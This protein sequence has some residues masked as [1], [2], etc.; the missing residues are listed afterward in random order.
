MNELKVVKSLPLES[1]KG[2]FA[3]GKDRVMIVYPDTKRIERWSLH[4]YEKELG[5]EVPYA[6][7]TAVAMGSAA[8]DRLALAYPVNAGSAV[9][10]LDSDQLKSGIVIGL[11]CN[12]IQTV[13]VPRQM[14]GSSPSLRRWAETQYSV[15]CASTTG[16]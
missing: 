5:A 13:C 6:N 10:L 9:V 4:T 15:R 2:L 3:A 8:N 16:W 14:V 12:Q 7:I 11:E 1:D